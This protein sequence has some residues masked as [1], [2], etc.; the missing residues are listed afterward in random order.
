M[1]R[2]AVLMLG[3][4][5]LAGFFALGTGFLI[6]GRYSVTPISTFQPGY[7][8]IVDRFTGQAMYCVPDQDCAYMDRP[9]VKSAH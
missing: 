2:P 5:L 1:N 7:V 4:V 6:G 8:V 3:I 9:K